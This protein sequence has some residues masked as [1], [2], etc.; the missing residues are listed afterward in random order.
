MTPSEV[1]AQ[2]GA[3]PCGD[4]K[5]SAHCP[6]HD[7][8]RDSL[9]IGA[10]ENGGT[11]LHCFAGCATADVLAKVGL[12]MADVM[13][14]SNDKHTHKGKRS[15][16][17]APS[18]DSVPHKTF[19][20][21]ESAIQNAI[22]QIANK[23]EPG[24]AFRKAWNYGE[25]SVVRFDLPTPAGEKQRKTFRPIW[26]LPNKVGGFQW[27]A[28][29]YPQPDVER[30]VYRKQHVAAAE[31]TMVVVC[32]G[33]KAADAA[34]GLKLVATTNAGG[35]Q[36]VDK[37]DWSPLSRF[38]TVAIVTDN[39]ETGES[40]GR[41]VAAALKKQ[42]PD[43]AVKIIALPDLPP[44]GD[45]VEWIGEGGTAAV[46]AEIVAATPAVTT[47]Q[48]AEWAKQERKRKPELEI[49]VGTDEGRVIDEAIHALGT[50]EKVFQR[51]GSLVHVVEG[52]KPPRGIVRA[53]D[54]PRIVGIKN[55]RLRELLADSAAWSRPA[56]KE[57]DDGDEILERIHPPDWVV[58][59]VIDRAQWPAK[60]RPLVAVVES[61][62][63]RAD[64]TV[65]CEPGYDASTGLLYQPTVDFPPLPTNQT[66]GNALEAVATLLE[67][68]ADFPF[69]HELHRAAWLASL[70]TP[71]SRY[72][73]HGPAPLNLYDAN[74]AGVGKGLLASI[75]AVIAT[76][77]EMSCTTMPHS[78]EEFRKRVTAI[79]IA[80]ESMVQLDNIP[81]TL[82]CSSLDAALTATS[83][84]DRLL[85]KSEMVSN[86]PLFATWYATGNNV[87][88][89]ADT[90]RRTLHIRLE[91]P[92]EDPEERSGFR[93]PDLLAWVRRERPRLTM[94][95]VTI[96]AAYYAAGRPNMRLKPWGSFEPWSDIVRQAIVWC[97][98]PDPA[99]TRTEL[100]SQAD[101][102]AVAL[103]QLV[104]GWEKADWENC[105]LTVAEVLKRITED[106]CG[107]YSSLRDALWE[108]SPPRD[109][110][111]LNPRGIGMKLHHLRR[112]VVGG[113]MLDSWRNSGN[114]VVWA[115]VS[116]SGTTGTTGTR[117]E[118]SRGK[119]KI[120][121]EDLERVEEGVGSSSGSSSSSGNG[122][123]QHR[124]VEYSET[125]DSYANRMCRDCGANLGCVRQE[126]V[127]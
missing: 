12:R 76:G 115:V 81:N 33:E 68:A 65:L 64:G 21:A 74:D 105:G 103:R 14:P 114:A 31:P 70:L 57:G 35:E 39:D 93:H 116:P 16:H 88:I 104:D 54:S 17:R 22:W 99:A 19:T 119:E 117:I 94:A 92:V 127:V 73:F 82:G 41:L 36:A 43:Q 100:N 8:Q 4:G 11:V 5:W 62:V 124:N 26:R 15:K 42:A 34:V 23:G 69:A 112:R 83:W 38:S 52:V 90:A 120:E 102:E 77:R 25:F 30:P 51:G 32:G 123:C 118:S 27:R 56:G 97:D 58:R 108:L 45:I 66:R 47:E 78:D 40:Y 86:V 89:A 63:L 96:L 13:P 98:L 3:Q 125:F 60:I 113:K 72:A 85:G 18:N 109:G 49:V 79:A 121:E 61:P 44:K 122:H 10:G 24:A 91:S 87:V 80:G 101:R 111:N 46:F 20:T 59:G 67:V 95:A 2:F 28:I 106:A 1:A 9:S 75:T 110:K 48:V 29:G 84:A 71:F 6:G 7:D 37:T 55:P 107:T 126:Q 53:K 50:C